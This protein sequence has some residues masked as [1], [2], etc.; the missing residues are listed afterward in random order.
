MF[1]EYEDDWNEFGNNIQC[2][3]SETVIS[4]SE[5]EVQDK[6]STVRVHM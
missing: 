1:S 2:R 4:S 3:T 5:S 6:T